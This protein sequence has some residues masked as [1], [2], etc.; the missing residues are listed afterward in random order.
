MRRPIRP[1]TVRPDLDVADKP[2][3]DRRGEDSEQDP[4]GCLDR[5]Q[6]S[7]EVILL[8]AKEQALI[9]VEA[10]ER[11]RETAAGQGEPAERQVDGNDQRKDRKAQKDD[12]RRQHHKPARIAVDPFVAALAR[13][14]VGVRCLSEGHVS[15]VGRGLRPLGGEECGERDPGA[16]SDAPG[17]LRRRRISAARRAF[18]CRTSAGC[19]RRSAG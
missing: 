19:R 7:D 13:S 17:V 5:L 2:I 9:V 12:D 16:P 11:Q 18:P 4:A 1:S 3:E 15:V 6:R 10:D 14:C 8:H